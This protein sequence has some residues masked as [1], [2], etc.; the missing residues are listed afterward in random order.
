M[1]ELPRGVKQWTDHN[2]F[3]EIAS[4]FIREMDSIHMGEETFEAL[5]TY[6]FDH[7]T[8]YFKHPIV[9]FRDET[10]SLE[11]R[12]KKLDELIIKY[13]GKRYP[14]R[15][16]LAHIFPPLARSLWFPP[17]C[18]ELVSLYEHRVGEVR[19]WKG[20]NPD[21]KVDEWRLRARLSPKAKIVYEGLWLW[22]D[23]RALA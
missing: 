14:V 13:Q 21:S 16:I 1:P 4:A 10:F 17:V 2:S 5:G 6:R 20:V 11:W 12:Q 22:D 18:S 3:P 9:I 23:R 7:L 15:Q 19:Y 8:N